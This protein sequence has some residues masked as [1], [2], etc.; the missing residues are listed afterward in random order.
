MKIL[1]KIALA[2]LRFVPTFD[3]WADNGPTLKTNLAYNWNQKLYRIK[4]RLEV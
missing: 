3:D 4:Q 2:M 1:R